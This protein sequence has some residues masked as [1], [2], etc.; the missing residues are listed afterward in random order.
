VA[1][2]LQVGALAVSVDLAS[3]RAKVR[4]QARNLAL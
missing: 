4:P 2:R 3:D 1:D